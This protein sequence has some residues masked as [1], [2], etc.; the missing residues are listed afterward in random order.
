MRTQVQIRA[1]LAATLLVAGATAAPAATGRIHMLPQATVA[2]VKVRLSDLAALEGRAV[3]FA[4]V[5]IGPSPEP[6]ASRRI[7]GQSVLARL[8]EAGMD[9]EVAYTIPA[10]VNVSRAYQLLD[11]ATLRPIIEA[12]LGDKLGPGDRIDA[13]DVPRPARIPLGAF[14]IEVEAPAAHGTGGGFRRTDLRVLQD[15]AQVATVG[16]RVKIASFGP[17]VVARQPVARGA[18]VRA[19][20]LRIEERRLDEMPSTVVS[21]IDEVIGKEARVALAAGKPISVQA[22]SSAALVKRGDVVRLTIE[23]GGMLLSVAG[24]ALETAGVGERV[25]VI[26]DSSKRELVGRVVDHGTVHVVY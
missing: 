11:E 8:R 9:D 20:D 13:I 21:E 22:I 17:V 5:E 25:R 26:N 19:E 10:T 15:G 14:E 2:G 3:D 12:Q 23:K 16:A 7:S 4:E 24:E 1:L 18:L 6:G